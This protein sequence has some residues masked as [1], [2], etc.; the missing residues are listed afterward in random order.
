VGLYPGNLI[1]QDTKDWLEA[2]IA[3]LNIRGDG[4]TGWSRG[5]KT[6]LW[7]RT[8]DGD[9][10][11]LIYEGL[12][13]SATLNNLWGFHSGS[14]AGT[15]SGTSNDRAGGQV[16]TGIYQI[17]GS[18]GGTAG[19]AEML[20]Q[21]H[22]GFL[23]PLPALPSVWREGSVKGLTAIGGFVVDIT[24]SN[25]ELDTMQ[26]TSS[27]GKECVIRYHNPS[28][29]RVVD[30]EGNSVELTIAENS[31]GF[32]TKKGETYFLFQE[33]QVSKV[34]RFGYARQPLSDRLKL[35]T[36]EI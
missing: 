35:E 33:L 3:S 12:I 23:R 14:Y 30:A 32:E 10:A 11:F 16:T 13:R 25:N 1:T 9:R 19:V 24:W 17:D 28:G 8:G 36:L 20:L 5:H 34:S 29:I 4:A 31:V 21:S 18:L 22:E 26:I 7:T 15:G 2:A 27:A 6:N